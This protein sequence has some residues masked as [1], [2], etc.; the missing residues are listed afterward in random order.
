MSLV[1]INRKLKSVTNNLI[2]YWSLNDSSFT[3]STNNG[4]T[5]TNFNGVTNGPGILG[6]DAVFSGNNRLGTTSVGVPTGSDFSVSFWV[7]TTVGGNNSH[8]LGA[9]FQTNFFFQFK[10]NGYWG[11]GNPF[12]DGTFIQDSTP[13]PLDGTW[14]HFVYVLKYGVGSYLYTNGVLVGTGNSSNMGGNVFSIGGGEYN[15]FYFTG[16]IDE[17]GIWGRALTAFEIGALYN[18]GVGVAYPF[19]SIIIPQYDICSI[20]LN[21]RTFNLANNL[22]S[23]WKLDETSGTRY[24]YTGHGNDLTVHNTVPTTTGLIGNCII[25]NGSGWLQTTNSLDFSG[26]FTINYWTIPNSDGTVQQFCGPSGSGLNFNVTNQ[27]I[28]HGLTNISINLEYYPSG[29]I[30]TTAW[31]MAT[32]MRSGSNISLYYN[33]NLVATGTDSHTDYSG[34]Y[35][36]LAIPDGQYVNRSNGAKIDEVGIWNRALT[37]REISFLYNTALGITYPFPNISNN[38]K[39]ISNFR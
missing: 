14:R 30:S 24:D 25:G 26:D 31:C 10:S 36:L 17:V 8:A 15:E 16:S 13:M 27:R 19:S 37:K 12:V 33:G 22:V 5:L 28:Y 32:F 11:G 23:Y 1:R 7:K 35:A 21:Y 20:I 9:P 18:S 29:G 38:C 34:A 6:D 39:I 2:A 4:Y 3:D